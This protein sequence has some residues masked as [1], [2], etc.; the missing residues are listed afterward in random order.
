MPHQA[1]Y[2]GGYAAAGDD[3]PTDRPPIQRSLRGSAEEA[4]D[5]H[6]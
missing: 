1:V 4:A 5:G 6:R 2:G 3:E